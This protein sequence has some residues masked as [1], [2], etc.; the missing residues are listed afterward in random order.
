[1]KFMGDRE[2]SV[3]ITKEDIQHYWRRMK[4]RTASSYFRRHFGHYK[5]AAHSKYLSKV[6]RSCKRP[7][8]TTTS[9]KQMTS[10]Q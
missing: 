8:S 6:R 4:E 5:A 3:I 2:V 1:M 10:K 7:S 9:R